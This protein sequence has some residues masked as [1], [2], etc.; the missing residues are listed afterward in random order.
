MNKIAVVQKER[1]FWLDMLIITKPRITGLVVMSTG[2]GYLLAGGHKGGEFV[3]ALL[4]FTFLVSVGANVLNQYIERNTDRLMPRTKN[5]PLPSGRV[6]P[7]VALMGGVACGLAGVWGL[8]IFANPLSAAMGAL[9]LV[10]Y[11][12]IY[13]PLKRVTEWNTLVGAVPGAI[14]APLGW[15]AASG[16]WNQQVWVLFLVMYVWQH[17]HTLSI[18]WLYREDYKLGGMRMIT[19]DDPQ[20]QRTSRQLILYSG[21]MVLVS[22]LPTLTGMTGKAYFVGALLLGA[23]FFWVVMG[24]VRHHD[25]LW[26]KR[27]LKTTVYYLPLL[28]LLMAM[29][30]M[31]L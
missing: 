5:R 28:L 19:V 15:V 1:A 25:N 27:L 14:P 4:F 10:S 17:P 11:V 24:M 21:L 20:G 9:V 3:T 26:A 12:G 7:L 29:D 30:L 23:G 31:P 22:L 8:Y 18:A 16:T 2:L 6:D 13:T